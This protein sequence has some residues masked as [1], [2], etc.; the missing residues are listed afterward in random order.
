M[1]IENAEHSKEFVD[2]V[3]GKV[4][5]LLKEEISKIEDESIHWILYGRIINWVFY[6]FY[7]PTIDLGFD[8]VNE[9]E[10]ENEEKKK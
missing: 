4:L 1:K 7:L 2:R 9:W 5:A 3:A 6:S 10:R 8:K